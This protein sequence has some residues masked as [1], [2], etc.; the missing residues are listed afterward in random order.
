MLSVHFW[1][2]IYA[3]SVLVSPFGMLCRHF[4]APTE[5]YLLLDDGLL[6]GGTQQLAREC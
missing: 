1:S 6:L 3:A 4:V 2:L 5:C